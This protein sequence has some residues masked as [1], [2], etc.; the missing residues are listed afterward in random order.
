MRELSQTKTAIWWRNYNKNGPSRKFNYQ[1]I[2]KSKLEELGVVDIIPDESHLSKWCIFEEDAFSPDYIKP[3]RVYLKTTQRFGNGGIRQAWYCNFYD[4]STQSVKL[5]SLATILYA[6]FI[7]TV[8]AKSVVD[9]IDENNMNESLDN[10]QLLTRGDNVKKSNKIWEMKTGLKHN[11]Q[12]T[13]N[14]LRKH[15]I[16]E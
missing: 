5:L 12:Y 10:Y 13:P 2:T 4:K 7:G 8:P 14:E 1:D 6:W 15:K 9:H 3:H 16:E 11:N